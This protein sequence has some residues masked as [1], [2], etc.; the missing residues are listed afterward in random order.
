MLEDIF[1]VKEI[2]SR[3]EKE[4]ISFCV[5]RNSDEL[6]RGDTHDIDM[7]IDFERY[8]DMI[9]IIKKISSLQGWKIHYFSEKDNG[10][11]L[12]VHLYKINNKK[13]LVIHFD[14]FREFGWKGYKLISNKRLLENRKKNEWL[15]E[16]DLAVQAVVMLFSRY[17]YHGYIKEKYKTFIC[18]TFKNQMLEVENV[19]REFLPREFIKCIIEDVIN[20]NWKNIEQ[21]R[22][23]VTKAI[24]NQ[25]NKS[26]KYIDEKVLFFNIKRIRKCTGV[27]VTVR[28]GKNLAEYGYFAMQV[29]KILERTFSREDIIELYSKSGG[30]NTIFSLE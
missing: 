17:L 20:E 28:G 15:Y 23:V 26:Q 3:F 19:M 9:S 14:F 8:A 4:N 7:A 13:P 30:Q 1:F 16:A 18:L 24:K 6:M 11:L 27:V 12:A 22:T 29:Q 10:N 21:E 5:L 2:F 25:L